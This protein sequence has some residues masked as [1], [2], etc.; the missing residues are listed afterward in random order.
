MNERKKHIKRIQFEAEQKMRSLHSDDI[1]QIQFIDLKKELGLK[2][3]E[4]KDY[5]NSLKCRVIIRVEEPT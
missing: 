1:V 5:I 2:Y 3:P 4:H